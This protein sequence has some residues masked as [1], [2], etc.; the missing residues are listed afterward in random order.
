[1]DA[2]T[3]VRLLDLNRQFY[4]TFG[5]EFAATRRRLQPGVGRIL[6]TLRGDENILD[7]GCGNGEL[8]RSLARRGHRGEY[9]GLDFSRPLLEGIRGLPGNFK[10][11]EADLTGDWVER[12]SESED[13]GI[14]ESK[15]QPSN[16]TKIRRIN[17]STKQRWSGSGNQRIN[18]SADEGFDLVTMF[19]VLH[20]IPGE[21]MRLKILHR[22]HAILSSSGRFVHSEWQFLNSVKLKARLQPWDQA[23]FSAGEV[24][25]GDYLI[26]WR[27]GGRGLRYVHHFE[28]AELSSLAETAGFR[29]VETFNSDG[30]GGNLSLYQVWSRLD[31][32]HPG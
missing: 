8:A 13:R 5:R 15:G 27:H 31:G 16:K 29:I 18:E 20:H 10:F 3:A 17:E 32:G 23:G 11:M 26:D 24:D 25:P 21:N 1:M 12:I 6:E 28:P 22:V 2:N 30:E 14:K 7:L 19:A 9:T 4:Q